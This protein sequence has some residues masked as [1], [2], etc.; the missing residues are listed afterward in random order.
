MR[1]LITNDDGIGSEG[2][3][4]LAL[5][6]VDAGLDVTVAAP[7][8]N[9]S[10]ASAS[11]SAVQAD[12][13]VMV[14]AHSLAGLDG[15]PA[16]GVGAAPA[17][18]TLIATRG[19]FGPPPDIVLSGINCGHNAGQAVLHSG[20]V[21]AALTG[22]SH[23]CRAMAVSLIAGD[24]LRWDTAVAAARRVLPALLEAP[25]PTVVNLNTP[26]VAPESLRGIQRA[27]LASFGAVQTNISEVGQGY[28]RL[29]MVDVDAELEAG[30]DAAY[31]ADGWAT[32]T[33]LQAICESAS[34]AFD[35]VAT[36]GGPASARR[37]EPQ[38]VSSR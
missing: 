19:A 20:T 29:E 37:P 24:P 26:D 6:A 35:T 32:V 38:E 30:T 31:L 28:V 2:L 33:P 1:A 25:A 9:V 18:I 14:D 3:R 27:R 11:L 8:D 12:G 34:D 16:Y 10:G 17:F 5:V 13:R 36:G 21:G 4:R 23:G 22:A 7:A 15:V